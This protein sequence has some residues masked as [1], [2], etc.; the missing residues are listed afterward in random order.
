MDWGQFVI[1]MITLVGI[2]IWLKQDI[3]TNRT[4]AAA[5]RRDILQL[6]RGIQEE[7]KDFHGRLERQDAEY[8]AHLMYHHNG[9]E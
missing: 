5:D 1:L 8:K 7:I 9:K 3:S 4:E 6:I 2:F